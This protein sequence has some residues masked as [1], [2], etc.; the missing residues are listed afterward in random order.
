VQALTDDGYL[1]YESLIS[2]VKWPSFV[3]PKRREDYLDPEEFLQIFNMTKGEFH[4]LK[5]FKKEYLKKSKKL[6]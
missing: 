1:P 5:S 4:A 3:D 6:F 2:G